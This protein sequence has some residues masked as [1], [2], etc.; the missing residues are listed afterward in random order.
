MSLEYQIISTIH[1]PTSVYGS[2]SGNFVNPNEVSLIVGKANRLE[3]Y[4]LK[5]KEIKLIG[6]QGS[7]TDSIFV[8]SEK[9]Q[10]GVWS[11][12]NDKAYLEI[13]FAG[14]ISEKVDKP[15]DSNAIVAIDPTNSLIAILSFQ[16]VVHFTYITSESSREFSS[17]NMH[18]SKKLKSPYQRQGLLSKNTYA[19]PRVSWNKGK[20]KELPVSSQLSTITACRLTPLCSGG[21]IAFSDSQIVIFDHNG[22]INSENNNSLATLQQKIGTI[23][24]ISHVKEHDTKE[25]I[26]SN[27]SNAFTTQKQASFQEKL[28]FGDDNGILWLM[29]LYINRRLALNF[30]IEKLGEIPIPQTLSYLNDGLL[31]I[32]SHYCDSRLVMLHENMT[33]A[34]SDDWDMKFSVNKKGSFLEIVQNFSSLSP[35]TD[36]CIIDECS[37]SL[38]PTQRN[39]RST[40]S[41]NFSKP[42]RAS[43]SLMNGNGSEKLVTCSGSRSKPSLRVV[44]SGFGIKTL[45]KVSTMPILDLKT[46][47]INIDD[48]PSLPKGT[49]VF[50]VLSFPNTTTLVHVNKELMTA[51]KKNFVP[52]NEVDSSS[53]GGFILD[54]TT[55]LVDNP[56][57]LDY[58]IQVTSKRVRILSNSRFLVIDE[59]VSNLGDNLAIPYTISLA[60]ISDNHLVVYTTEKKVV[61]F[62]ILK[63]EN[64]N[65]QPQLA[66]VCE[67][68]VEKQISAL[69]LRHV[70]AKSAFSETNSTLKLPILVISYW[71][72]PGFTIFSLPNLKT[73]HDTMELSSL[74][75]VSD[76]IG[77]VEKA[78]LSIDYQKHGN[79]NKPS[80]NI[81]K[82][83]I[84]SDNNF[85]GSNPGYTDNASGAFSGGR[86]D[87]ESY[88]IR[89][90]EFVEFD[91]K[92][93]MLAGLSD[94][95]LLYFLIK[96]VISD[97]NST[98]AQK[99]EFGTAK[100]MTF[101]TL[102]IKLTSFVIGGKSQVFIATDKPALM[103]SQ[104]T[105]PIFS[106]INSSTVLKASPII[107]DI[108]EDLSNINPLLSECLFF[109]DK[110]TL[111]VNVIDKSQNIHIDTIPLPP[112]ESPYKVAYYKST[113]TI[114]LCSIS[115]IP[116]L[117]NMSNLDFSNNQGNAIEK[118]W[119]SV[120]D[121]S[122][123]Q[124]LSKIG[125]PE[126]E[127]PE[128][129][130]V[131]TLHMLPKNHQPGLDNSTIQFY[132]NTSNSTTESELSNETL[133]SIEVVAVGTSITLADQDDASSGHIYLFSFNKTKKKLIQV[134]KI[135][136][137][138]AVYSIISFKGML[139]ASINNTVVL[140]AWRQPALDSQ[141]QIIDKFFSSRQSNNLEGLSVELEIMSVELSHVVAL[142]LS[143]PISDH[144]SRNIQEGTDLSLGK[145][146]DNFVAVGDLMTGVSILQYQTYQTMLDNKKYS[147]SKHI[148]SNLSFHQIKSDTSEF[149]KNS[150]LTDRNPGDMSNVNKEGTNHTQSGLQLQKFQTTVQHKIEEVSREYTNSWVT[151]LA[152]VKQNSTFVHERYSSNHYINSSNLSDGSNYD[153]NIGISLIVGENGLNLYSLFYGNKNNGENEPNSRH[154]KSNKKSVYIAGNAE[155]Q[156]HLSGRYHIGDLVNSII[157]GTLI[158]NHYKNEAS[159]FTPE[160][161]LGTL[162]GAIYAKIK[163]SNMKVGRVLD[164]LQINMTVLGPAAFGGYTVFS[165]SHKNLKDFY[166]GYSEQHLDKSVFPNHTSRFLA[167]PVSAWSHSYFRTYVNLQ[168]TCRQFGFIDGDLVSLFLYYPRE[169]QM[170]I[171]NGGQNPNSSLLNSTRSAP[172]NQTDMHSNPSLDIDPGSSLFAPNSF[173]ISRE[174]IEDLLVSDVSSILETENI[175][176]DLLIQILESLL[177]VS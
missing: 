148:S 3:T 19:T 161:L 106:H 103:Y 138:G 4:A 145:P 159:D 160:L 151:A 79:L 141:N 128:S 42:A 90:M 99:I 26:L 63:P 14:F 13:Q 41:N 135:E 62:S 93:Y 36:M 16:G 157:P 38:D 139:L 82:L 15:L 134:Q 169:L 17:P 12:N 97:Q 115:L 78:N 28:F 170:Y 155:A 123:F 33:T 176:L 32:G 111:S 37:E 175:S 129:L 83:S 61:Y 56:G 7:K 24:S 130:A 59:W 153:K 6:E 137:K 35:I 158:M 74:N 173:D 85:L 55:V 154:V 162:S 110:G 81:E 163:L 105:N 20:G 10:F 100:I 133:P 46:V 114:A 21:F 64:H 47:A 168:Q 165:D 70:V 104:G 50:L 68:K 142:Q 96:K 119:F 124:T 45:G 136:T 57:S 2:V 108:L 71:T 86:R 116:R 25:S 107:P 84:S 88:L 54:E 18:P 76:D 69:I 51:N 1:K 101:G 102:P 87:K 147:K 140:Y 167:S 43:S 122:D 143:A 72:R 31:Y 66:K 98:S 117:P 172:S 53:H 132:K 89:D 150:V 126:N 166:F 67:I 92:T 113:Q 29:I 91:N 152:C 131:L 58:I 30:R 9:R 49:N 171:F 44:K 146:F 120:L 125:F 80:V 11:W 118:G 144:N 22:K 156:L 52:L 112:W 40:F 8:L 75:I 164:R 60:S 77:T 34:D 73:I 39:S 5:G 127:L 23:N 48:S 174:S 94:G 65:S 109:I 95:R 27:N 177:L 121:Q 149:G